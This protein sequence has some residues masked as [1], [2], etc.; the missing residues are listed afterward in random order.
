MQA[1]RFRTRRRLVRGMFAAAIFLSVAAVP[2]SD[3]NAQASPPY[4]IGWHFISSGGKRLNNSCFVLNGT[5]GQTAPGY[6][7]GGGFSVLAGFWTAAPTVG[8]DQLFFDGFERC[9]P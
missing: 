6:S 7:S 1:K 2:W 5:A 9:A 8:Q 3:G 4:S